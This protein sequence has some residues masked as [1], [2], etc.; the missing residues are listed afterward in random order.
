MHGVC[1]L[2]CL[3]LNYYHSSHMECLSLALSKIQSIR[4][5]VCSSFLPKPH[6]FQRWGI[7]LPRPS[8]LLKD[9]FKHVMESAVLSALLQDQ[10]IKTYM[11]CFS[12]PQNV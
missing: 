9:P 8:F 5:N 10:E 3:S 11:D 1:P 4:M 6:T 2:L 7:S 12:L